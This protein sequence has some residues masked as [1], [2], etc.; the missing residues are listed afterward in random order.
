[1]KKINTTL[2]LATILIAGLNCKSTESTVSVTP[3]DRPVNEVIAERSLIDGRPYWNAYTP[4]DTEKFFYV[5][6]SA[7]G[8]DTR[9][10]S[11]ITNASNLAIQQ[12]AQKVELKVQ[13][14]QKSFEETITND[15]QEYYAAIFS[16]AIKVTIEQTIYGATKL[17]D[18]CLELKIKG[19][20]NINT[21]CYVLFR[22]P[23]EQTKM[24]YENA[25][26]QDDMLYVKFKASKAYKELK[27]EFASI[28]IKD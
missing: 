13:A 15:D 11:V 7:T 21:E 25:L 17:T 28:E 12:M 2:F 23:T 18:R 5:S 14:I 3:F 19:R 4:L 16:N 1:M 26:S 8:N 22:M 20:S 24:A 27:E 6:A 10:Q 9:R